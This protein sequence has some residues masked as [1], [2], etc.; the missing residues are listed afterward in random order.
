MAT[1]RTPADQAP[2]Q[3][4]EN[5]I[6]CSPYQ[7]PL[8]HWRYDTRTGSASRQE[9]RREASY[10]FKS[11]RTGTRQTSLLAEEE[12]A[13]LPLVNWLREDI[14]AWRKG[15]YRG[16]TNV[17]KEL[18]AHWSHPDRGR[19]L[20]FCQREAVETII[21]LSEIVLDQRPDAQG[22]YRSGSI[23]ACVRNQ[24]ERQSWTLPAEAK[25]EWSLDDPRRHYARP[26]DA[27]LDS[28]ADGGRALRRLGAKMAT[29]SGK[30]VVMSMLIAWTL[31]NR[32]YMP[33]DERF[34]ASVLVVGPN[35]TVRER[36]KVLL[37]EDAEN[38]YARFDIVPA[39]YRE[40]LRPGHVQVVNWHKLAPEGAHVEGGK[41]YAVVN[42]GEESDEAFARRVLGDAFE[43]GPLLVLNDEA[44]HAWRPPAGAE[45]SGEAKEE[46]EEA[47]I[48]VD[49]LDRLNR[50]VGI[51]VCADLSATPFY[52]A[53]SGQPE[54]VPFP[55]LV[56]DF[57]LVDAIESGI[58][59]IPRLPVSDTTG[60]PEPKYFRLWH[61]ITEKLQPADKLPGRAGKP[62]PEAVWRDAQDALNTLSA[63][64]KSRFE[65][66]LDA[67]RGRIPPVLIVVCDNTDIAR[68]L[69][70][71]VSGETQEEYI[72]EDGGKPKKK[73]RTVYGASAVFE[74]FAN[75]AARRHTLRIDSKLLAAAE[76]D[77]PEATRDEAAQQLRR[78]VDTVGRPGEPGEHIRCVVSVSM[79][80]EG[81]DANNVTHILGLRAFGS[82]LLCEQ[83]VGRGLRRMDY[84]PDPET[85]LLRAEYVD[86]YGIPFSV[87][88]FKGRSTTTAAPEDKPTTWVRARD[89]RKDYEMSF[90][91]VEGYV[92]ALNK[93]LIR[94]DVDKVE[95]LRLTPDQTPTGVFVK[96]QVGYQIGA[97][98]AHGPGASEL[99]DRKVF[100][101]STHLQTIQFE[102]A[103]RVVADLASTA[104]G[105]KLKYASRHQ[106]FPQVY[107]IVE[108]FIDRRVDWNGVAD[109]REIGLERYVSLVVER[110]VEGIRPDTSEGEPPLLPLLNRFQ[111][112][113]STASVTFKTTRPCFDTTK[114]HI[115]HVVADTQ[116]WEQSASFYLEASEFV[117]FY[118]RNDH[119]DLVIPY[120]YFNVQHQYQPD[121]LVRLTDGR[122]LILEIKG[123]EDEQD[124][125]KHQ[126]A[127]R[128]VEAVNN[129]GQMGRWMFHVCRNPQMLGRELEGLAKT[130]EG[131]A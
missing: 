114:S 108:Q 7:E 5:P 31:C 36:L 6:L 62:K 110:L 97:P 100:Y 82:Q 24:L 41:S 23:P 88:P 67:G 55:W 126:A 119:L 83:V 52:I 18:L 1:P 125:Q 112:R 11:A 102:I 3:A 71:Y 85:G 92:F 45:V 17:T 98:T 73:S 127:K 89:D 96:P 25:D 117:A 70:E 15:G 118:G 61:N 46:V 75:T 72:E 120:D 104:S 93:G 111:P 76:S 128:W 107:R 34:P 37:P 8:L 57:G 42:K 81:W 48:W 95:L 69:Y 13:D 99:Q 84:D 27:L 106:L 121:F 91:V 79:L 56:S 122:T 54:G 33:S 74:E 22:R 32:G 43:R 60:R 40:L 39:K 78:M 129:W 49:G 65:Q 86:V 21:F 58:V 2:V 28:P 80:T 9:G 59:K 115:D 124:R 116:T 29:G 35:L 14:R 20:F 38:Y 12:R 50:G 66:N 105:G 10:W 109:Q 19:K 123:A 103:R 90:P 64:W 47:T 4:V 87:I 63:Q 26:L 51:R 113:A 131:A 130:G 101:E 44:H 30:T 77:D 53:G 68:L 94:C 16:A